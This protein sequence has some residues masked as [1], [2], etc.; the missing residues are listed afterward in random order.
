M[1]Y[2]CKRVAYKYL[3]E[4]FVKENLSESNVLGNYEE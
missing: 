4:S 3:M 2:E 1:L